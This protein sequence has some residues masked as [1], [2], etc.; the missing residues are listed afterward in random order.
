MHTH[1]RTIH[2]G[3]LYDYANKVLFLGRE[4]AFREHT[5]DLAEF[6]TLR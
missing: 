6:S 5:V 4:I 1:G 2:H 3:S